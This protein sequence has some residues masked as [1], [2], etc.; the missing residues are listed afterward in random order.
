MVE[1]WPLSALEGQ[2]LDV[3]AG[4]AGRTHGAGRL[5]MDWLDVLVSIRYA[6]VCHGQA[7]AG[8]AR[9]ARILSQRGR[10]A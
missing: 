8:V 2:A 1:R 3:V 5:W 6:P 7:R 4:V 9:R 10:T